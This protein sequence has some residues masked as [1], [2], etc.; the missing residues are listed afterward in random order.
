M[1]QGSEG[2]GKKRELFERVLCAGRTMYTENV[3][4]QILLNYTAHKE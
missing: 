2:G 4:E 3:F 1:S